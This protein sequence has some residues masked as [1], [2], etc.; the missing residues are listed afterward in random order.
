MD[1]LDVR[2]IGYIILVPTPDPACNAQQPTV[3]PKTSTQIEC[4]TIVISILAARP[5]SDPSCPA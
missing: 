5:P 4:P 2:K 1:L 3:R